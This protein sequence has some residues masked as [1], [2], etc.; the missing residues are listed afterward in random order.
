MLRRRM[1]RSG[2]ITVTRLKVRGLYL[3]YALLFAVVFAVMLAVLT[4]AVLLIPAGLL[5]AV[6]GGAMLVFDTGFILTELSPLIM[7]FGGLFAASLSAFAG[8][9]AVRLGML[10]WR[11]FL[12]VRCTC[13]RLRGWCA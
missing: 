9:C 7:L 11:L 2:G 10:V 4:S 5:F 12:K 1:I 6:L 13:D 8:L 3:A